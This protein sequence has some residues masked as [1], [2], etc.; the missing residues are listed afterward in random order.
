MK[1]D[2]IQSKTE[3]LPRGTIRKTRWYLLEAL[4]LTL[5]LTFLLTFRVATESLATPSQT[6]P[7]TPS[8]A[9]MFLAQSSPIS[10]KRPT[11][12]QSPSGARISANSPTV[13]RELRLEMHWTPQSQFA[14]YIMAIEKHFYRDA[15][16][17]PIKLIWNNQDRSFESLADGSDFCTGW[18]ADGLAA[19]NRGLAIVELAQYFDKPSQLF[20]VRAD[21]DIRTPQDIQ[22]R[23][24]GIFGGNHGVLLRR[25][26]ETQKIQAEV[27]PQS[28]SL[29]PFLRGA[30]D[31]C[32]AMYY[33]EYNRLIEA[34]LRPEQLRT[35]A[36]A[37]Y[38]LNFP[39]D[40]LFTSEAMWRNEPELCRKLVLAT[41]RGWEY[42]F[43]P[44]HE[45]ETL[46]TVLRYASRV[47]HSNPNHQ[48]WMLR[49]IQV[50]FPQSR[51]DWGR[52]SPEV[53][54]RLTKELMAMGEITTIVPFEA[55]YVGDKI[56]R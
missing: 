51:N 43:D 55:F 17:P 19:R 5:T 13:H 9:P 31:V 18:L 39:E 20:V 24:V 33:N 35:F 8:Q 41:Q 1:Y 48:R 11:S 40:A 42:A 6:L 4:T 34:G 54:Q 46:E 47:T 44:E 2:A 7:Q 22:G 14:G 56:L 30:I 12:P 32:S 23:R 38:G 50:Q 36:L 27:I 10:P 28:T 16:L 29:V 3:F 21:S 37:D 53:Y 49:A 45:Q 15:G 26:L 52:L 25:F